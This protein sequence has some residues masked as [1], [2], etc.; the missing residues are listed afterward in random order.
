MIMSSVFGN[1]RLLSLGFYVPSHRDWEIGVSF[2]MIK[3]Q[4]DSSLE[5]DIPA[6]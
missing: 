1:W 4:R 5:K 6:L 2:M 3:F